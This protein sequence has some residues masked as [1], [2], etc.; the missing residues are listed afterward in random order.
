MQWFTAPARAKAGG[1][2]L[3]CRGKEIDV[4]ALGARGATWPAEYAGGFDR[5]EKQPSKPGSLS[6]MA[7]MV[8][9]WRQ[10]ML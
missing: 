3:T 1:Q 9:A 8:L 2:G 6:C 5:R 7:D 4:A 10:V